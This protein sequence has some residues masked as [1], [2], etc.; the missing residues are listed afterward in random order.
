MKR[1]LAWVVAVLML[2]S[3]S[4]CFIIHDHGGHGG[5]G[6]GY[7]HYDRNHFGGGGPHR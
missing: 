3:L 4:G 7:E 1:F 2:I 6:G 5:R